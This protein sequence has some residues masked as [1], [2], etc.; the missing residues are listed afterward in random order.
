M[1]YTRNMTMTNNN[2]IRE[3]RCTRL[4]DGRWRG[5]AYI[6]W[7]GGTIE[8]TRDTFGEVARWCI[9]LFERCG[10]YEIEED[11]RHG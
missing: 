8:I 5:V 1:T 6:G 4:H 9:A 11:T 7:T 2:M 10:G 3:T